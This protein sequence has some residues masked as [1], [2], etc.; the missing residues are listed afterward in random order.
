MNRY[1]RNLVNRLLTLADEAEE[2]LKEVREEFGNDRN[3]APRDE[4]A[5]LLRRLGQLAAEA[6]PVKR[7]TVTVGCQ[8]MP[9][10]GTASSKDARAARLERAKRVMPKRLYEE[11]MRIGKYPRADIVL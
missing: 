9:R 2:I 11:I 10:P 1:R 3:A 4:V 5:T 8:P 6:E 7:R